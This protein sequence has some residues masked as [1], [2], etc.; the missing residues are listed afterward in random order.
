MEPDT[1]L[2][3]LDTLS[4]DALWAAY[5]SG[6]DEALDEV[7]RRHGPELLRYL[8]LSLGDPARALEEL[9][10][11]VCRAA[12]WRRPYEGFD[13]LRGWLLAVATQVSTPAAASHE[14][15]LK[16]MLDDLRRGEPGTDQEALRRAVCDLRRDL[17]QPFLLTVVLGLSAAEATKACRA[18]PAM[19]ARNA[20]RACR[21]LAASIPLAPE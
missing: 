6:R 16:E 5:V 15:G 12:A 14:E 3:P 10:R 11:S 7:I 8:H 19:V 21:A 2:E 18:T 9:G 4:D 20:A 13:S 1:T 17:R